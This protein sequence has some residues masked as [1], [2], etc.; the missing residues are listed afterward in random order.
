MRN[1]Q[2]LFLGILWLV[3]ACVTI[4]Y[5]LKRQPKLIVQWTTE[6]EVNTAGFN[7]YRAIAQDGPYEQI[8]ARLIPS[9]GDPLA[10]SDYEY[11]DRDVQLN[12]Q[13]F[14]QLEDVE[15]NGQANRTELT[16]GQTPGRQTWILILAG[17][18][19]LVGLCLIFSSFGSKHTDLSRYGTAGNVPHQE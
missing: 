1:R 8:N 14:Y 2:L 18:G 9:N 16:T 7:I 11:V 19:I 6:T 17:V 15:V 5:E 12:Q 13:Y 10:G 3:L 4:G